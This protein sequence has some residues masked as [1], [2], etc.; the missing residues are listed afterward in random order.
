MNDLT[1]QSPSLLRALAEASP[2]AIAIS[3]GA[4][5]ILR[6]VNPAFCR[7]YKHTRENLLGRSFEEVCP[8]ASRHPAKSLLDRVY[9]SGAPGSLADLIP[10]EDGD[11]AAFWS[12][13]A[14]PLLDQNSVASQA[15][16][17]TRQYAADEE[18]RVELVAANQQLL[19]A[20]LRED[21]RAQSLVADAVA[22]DEFLAML[23]HEL[24][25]P[26]AAIQN[27][28]YILHQRA[29]ADDTRAHNTLTMV[30]RQ[31]QHLRRMLDDLL[32]LSR[33]T[34]GTI[35]LRKEPLDL[36]A[37]V[38][39]ALEGCHSAVEASKHELSIDLPQGPVEV[40]GDPV[41]L[42]QIVANLL[43]NAVKYMDPEGKIWVSLT[44]LEADSDT[45]PL[46]APAAIVTIRDAGI[47][48]SPEAIGRIFEPFTQVNP[49]SRSA[50]SGMGIGLSLVRNLVRLHGGTVEAQSAGLGHGSE[51]RVTL[52]LR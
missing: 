46:G 32:D 9:A 18:L 19:L 43:Q 48:I 16:D 3:E 38:K 17:R 21:Q 41:R 5:H 29:A 12:F 27:G 49:S 4:D 2:L 36:V 23:A 51:F 33:F 22:K 13:A 26:V 47:G 52:P 8:G 50:Q 11:A 39:Q 42:H 1:D 45:N 10:P 28:V 44:T 37:V 25:N 7:L 40:F 14:W 20:G 31:L 15:E 30:E 34:R 35:E 24:R 6:Y